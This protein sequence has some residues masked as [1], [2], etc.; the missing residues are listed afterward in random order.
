M[1]MFDDQ[2]Y[3]ERFWHTA[4]HIMAQ[5]VAELRGLTDVSDIASLREVFERHVEASRLITQPGKTATTTGSSAIS[6]RK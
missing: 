4:S 6:E 3:R 5:A 1:N 2:N